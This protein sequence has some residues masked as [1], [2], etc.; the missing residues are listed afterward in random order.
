MYRINVSQRFFSKER[1]AARK[2]TDAIQNV[3]AWLAMSACNPVCVFLI[4]C[5]WLLGVQVSC[6]HQE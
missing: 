5:P 6:L 2:Y 3:V 1:V 4:M